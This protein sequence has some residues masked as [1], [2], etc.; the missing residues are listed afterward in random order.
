M[1]C[2]VAKPIWRSFGPVK[3]KIFAWLATKYRLCTSDR[4]AR[5][6]L[7]EHPDACLTC[8]QE[9]DN[10]DHVLIQCVFAREVWLGCLLKAEL[11]IQSPGQ[12][13]TLETW[14]LQARE[15]F[16]KQDRRKFDTLVILVAWMLWKQRN[17]QVFGRA[18]MHSPAASCEG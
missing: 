6:G 11:Q 10:V 1:R 16:R 12:V 7:Q 2:D 15:R 9:E 14:W 5:H 3:C 18:S 4:R 17:A 8:L 13:D